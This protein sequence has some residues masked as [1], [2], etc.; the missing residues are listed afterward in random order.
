MLGDIGLLTTLTLMQQKQKTA[1]AALNCTI[2]PCRVEIQAAGHK[3]PCNGHLVPVFLSFVLGNN[4]SKIIYLK[5][6]IYGID[7]EQHGQDYNRPRC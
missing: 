6:R 4:L 2:L 7:F 5:Y 1:R 3:S